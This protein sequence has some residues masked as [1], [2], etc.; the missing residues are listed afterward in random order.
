MEPDGMAE[1]EHESVANPPGR[2][3]KLLFFAAT[4][5]IRDPA[6]GVLRSYALARLPEHIPNRC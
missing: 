2:A 6:L 5:P 3:A 4:V 1:K